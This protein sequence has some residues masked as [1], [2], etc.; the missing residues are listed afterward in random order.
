MNDLSRISY[1]FAG[2]LSRQPGKVTVAQALLAVAETTGLTIIIG[3]EVHVC[4]GECQ[5]E[6]DETSG[7]KPGHESGKWVGVVVIAESHISV[8]GQRRDAYCIIDTCRPLEDEAAARDALAK[9]LKGEWRLANT[10]THARS[11]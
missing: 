4:D 3:P 8:S 1:T 2:K 6:T 5:E 7:W 10:F 9:A 11:P